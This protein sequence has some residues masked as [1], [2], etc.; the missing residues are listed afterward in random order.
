MAG[1]SG[2][3][4]V[5]ILSLEVGPLLSS[6][7]APKWDSLVSLWPF[8]E[9]VDGGSNFSESSALFLYSLGE[10]LLFPFSP[11][12]CSLSKCKFPTV[13]THSHRSWVCDFS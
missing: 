1:G 7:G 8:R 4:I 6:F 12:W 9:F 3:I 2:E 10:P 5:I 13:L 11:L